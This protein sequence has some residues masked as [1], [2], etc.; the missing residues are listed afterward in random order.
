VKSNKQA[1]KTKK[2]K[3]NNNNN[4]RVFQEHA[5]V[6]ENG[7]SDWGDLRICNRAHPLKQ[8]AKV[9]QEDAVALLLCFELR[10]VCQD[11]L[12]ALRNEKS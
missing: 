8:I 1:K 7:V 2:K 9:L 3:K 11:S 6:V 10:L 12:Q 5:N 4:V